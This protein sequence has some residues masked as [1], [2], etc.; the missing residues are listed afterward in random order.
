MYRS[1]FDNLSTSGS[2]RAETVAVAGVIV[3]AALAIAMRPYLLCA[4]NVIALFHVVQ[5]REHRSSFGNAKLPLAWPV[6][7]AVG[8]ASTGDKINDDRNQINEKPDSARDADEHELE[9]QADHDEYNP[10][11][12]RPKHAFPRRNAV[13]YR[14]WSA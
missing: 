4:A 8:A 5:R 3:A 11:N 14:Q 10:A 6:A 2:V 12:D 9:L 7:G 13:D 1:C